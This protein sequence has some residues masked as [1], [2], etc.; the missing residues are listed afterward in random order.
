MANAL[1]RGWS[2]V[3]A[4]AFVATA[5]VGPAGV[6]LA[7]SPCDG[8]WLPGDGIPGSSGG[9]GCSTMWDPDGPGPRSPLLV[10]GGSFTIIGNAVASNIAAYDPQTGLWT[11][12]GA[13]MVGPVDGLAALP[14]GDL[15][16][17]GR[18]T[19]AGGAPIAHIA[20]W[21]GTIWSPLGSGTNGDVYAVTALPNGDV[22]AGGPFSQAGGAPANGIARWN[23][24]HWSALGLGVS[25]TIY[26]LRTMPNGDVLSGGHFFSAGGTAA[27]CIAKWNGT[28]WSTLSTG[29]GGTTSA[30][31]FG[32]G[33]FPNG[34]V[35]AAGTF[36]TAGGVA[37]QNVARWNGVQWSALAG[38]VGEGAY[39]AAVLPNGD[40]L[41][42]GYRSLAKWDGTAWSWNGLY[43]GN[44]NVYSITPFSANETFVGGSFSSI[45]NGPGY[46]STFGVARWNGQAWLPMNFGFNGDVTGL[47]SMP[48]G[49]L[50]ACGRFGFAGGVPSNGIARF[51]GTRWSSFGSGISSGFSSA[52]LQPNGD[53]VALGSFTSVNGA[54]SPHVARLSGATWAP[55]GSGIAGYAISQ[56]TLPDGDIVIGGQFTSA[57]GVP[58]NNITRWDGLTWFPLG[59]GLDSWVAALAVSPS[60]ELFAGGSFSFDGGATRSGV[61][62]WNGSSWSQVGQLSIG[63]VGA[64]LALSNGDV[65]AASDNS[66][67][68]G[69]AIARWNGS[70]WT[71]LGSGFNHSI[72]AMAER[73][74]GDIVA[75]GL[76]T[77]ADGVAANHVALWNGRAWGPIGSGTDSAVNAVRLLANGDLAV[78]GSFWTA[79]SYVSYG[80]ARYHFGDTNPL[81]IHQPVSRLICLSGGAHFSLDAI[82]SDNFAYQWQVQSAP[83]AWTPL[84]VTPVALSCGGTASAT[85]PSALE[86]DV[87]VAPCP[88]AGSLAPQQF[89]VRCT[90]TNACGSILSADAVY[91]TCPADFNCSGS[92]STQDIFDFLN[93]WFALDPRADVNGSGTLDPQ[94]IFDFVGA[95]FA[96]C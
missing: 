44:G 68:N 54:A 37:V 70:S 12:L 66:A 27:P 88:A 36:Y 19:A 62:R 59:Q 56:A 20:R 26:V 35:V 39:A 69:N 28:A 57:G 45:G 46:L 65:L 3:C 63:W 5:L 49:D 1:F 7:Q 89:H 29:L 50:V 91:T 6:V 51:D 32:L 71:L 60:G 61:A 78:S 43:P 13:G 92:L 41:V 8:G 58:A 22:I 53:L 96:G 2:T 4:I 11:A 74:N 80:V 77:I 84:G 82:G 73:P 23:G 42:S 90:I 40:L 15:I 93:A 14:N 18:F 30:V 16:A 52:R 38:G 94:D 9:V 67:P 64:L 95:W 79:G 72:A 10:V 31:V 55:L 25:G 85:A 48:N 83:G 17:C 86:T 34:D 24:T 75:G 33:V 47:A 76:F 81:I 21:N 87:F